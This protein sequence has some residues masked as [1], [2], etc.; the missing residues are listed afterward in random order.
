MGPQLQVLV[1]NLI[2]KQ[3]MTHPTRYICQ[4]VTNINNH[5]QAHLKVAKLQACL[6][7]QDICHY[8]PLYTQTNMNPHRQKLVAP[9]L[10]Y[11]H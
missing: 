10:D 5:M 2:P 3:I 11:S 9:T 1:V 4:W 7:T 8:F 6:Q